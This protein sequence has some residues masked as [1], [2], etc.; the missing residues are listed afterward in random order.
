MSKDTNQSIDENLFKLV[1]LISDGSISVQD[2]CH[3]IKQ[4]IA[5]EVIRE[6]DG[7]KT[8]N[9]YHEGD[10]MESIKERINY[11]NKIANKE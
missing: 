8:A 11:W 3:D 9:G 2:G 1:C 5:T 7:L 6:L 10:W 4:L